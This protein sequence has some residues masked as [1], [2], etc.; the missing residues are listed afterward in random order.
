MHDSKENAKDFAFLKLRPT[1]K[2]QIWKLNGEAR[3]DGVGA[4]GNGVAAL[5]NTLTTVPLQLVV[6]ACPSAHTKL[7]VVCARP[8][9][10]L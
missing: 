10:R 7:F 4:G 8:N 5:G 6:R 1:H 3:E 9:T 2:S